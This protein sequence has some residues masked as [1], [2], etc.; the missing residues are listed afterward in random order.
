MSPFLLQLAERTEAPPEEVKQ[1]L[2]RFIGHLQG[3]ISAQGSAVVPGLGTFSDHG[4]HMAFEPLPALAASVNHRFAGLE[5]VTV[6]ASDKAATRHPH[7]PQPEPAIAN[8]HPEAEEDASAVWDQSPEE[9][10][11]DAETGSQEAAEIGPWLSAVNESLEEEQN[12][13]DHQPMQSVDDNVEPADQSPRTEEAPPYPEVKPWLLHE[14]ETTAASNPEAP[15]IRPD[16]QTITTGAVE[17]EA[18]PVMETSGSS[19][20]AQLRSALDN[21]SWPEAEAGDMGMVLKAEKTSPAEP[22]SRL[23]RS[24]PANRA[25]SSPRRGAGLVAMGI[26]FTV[27]LAALVYSFTATP[28]RQSP[29][30][31]GNVTEEA[32]SPRP[33]R[34]QPAPAQDPSV[35]AASPVVEEVQPN[36]PEPETPA[37]ET[38]GRSGAIDPTQEGYTLVI[39]SST[40]RAD[41]QALAET[42]RAQGQETAVLHGPF[43]GVTRYRVVLGQF[44][45]SQEANQ[46]KRKIANI[47]PEGAWIMSISREMEVY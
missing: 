3:R 29:T 19:F 8:I 22:A 34:E 13:F 14:P 15:G 7:E 10:L 36:Q 20:D 47:L 40:T 26:L 4:G 32:A 25:E 39:G 42:F 17:D 18:L 27:A 5:P 21:S 38:G 23:A 46:R 24:R 11:Y 41:A 45:T 31:A 43:N 35:A 37:T 2:D 12:A 6:E 28:T 30:E 9:P 33:E 44:A 16:D 1:A